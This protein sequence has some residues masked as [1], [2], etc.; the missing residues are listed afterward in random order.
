MT[1]FLK[2]HTATFAKNCTIF[3]SASCGASVD[4]YLDTNSFPVRVCNYKFTE[5]T[6]FWCLT[7]IIMIS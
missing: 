3:F 4:I 2:E 7:V 1:S 5:S 6:D